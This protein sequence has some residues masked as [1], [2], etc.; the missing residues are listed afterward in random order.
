MTEDFLEPAAGPPTRGGRWRRR[1]PA[2]VRSRPGRA[3]PGWA[4]LRAGF[5]CLAPGGS[6]AGGDRGASPEAAVELP[7]RA[8]IPGLPPVSPSSCWAE[9]PG[10]A[11]RGGRGRAGR[12]AAD[13]PHNVSLSPLLQEHGAVGEA[14]AAG[15]QPE[16]G[17]AA[18]RLQTL[19]GM[20]ECR[21]QQV[22]AIGCAQV[23]SRGPRTHRPVCG[24]GRAK[25][26]GWRDFS[27]IGVLLLPQIACGCL[28]EVVPYVCP[29]T[30]L[31]PCR[32]RCGLCSL[33]GAAEASWPCGFS[34]SVPIFLCPLRSFRKASN[35]PILHHV[36]QPHEGFMFTFKKIKPFSV[37]HFFSP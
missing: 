31:W 36:V 28:A 35:Q 3:G 6:P 1:G 29:V 2:G 19:L 5:V 10:Q 32:G 20:A 12:A 22:R 34:P 37:K 26:Q 27:I 21:V 8:L 23:N 14:G 9:G 13:T 25:S 24:A 30:R 17:A 33:P 15:V 7:L 16:Q 18:G 4:P 11:L